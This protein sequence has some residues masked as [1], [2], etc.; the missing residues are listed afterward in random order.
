[1]DYLVPTYS[2][3]PRETSRS[4]PSF[5]KRDAVVPMCLTCSYNDARF[6]GCD[7]SKAAHNLQ[8][9]GM[10]SRTHHSHAHRPMW[11]LACGPGCREY[12][13]RANRLTVPGAGNCFLD[14]TRTCIGSSP[15][16]SPNKS[17]N[18]SAKT[19]S[20]GLAKALANAPMSSDNEDGVVVVDAI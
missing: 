1:V 15:N 17:P 3:T 9:H 19:A 10:H 11:C 20:R 14:S 4:Q 13:S 18:N 8:G 6:L 12:Q 2:N 5:A 16:K 7:A